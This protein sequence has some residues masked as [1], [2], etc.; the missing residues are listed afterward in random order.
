[1]KFLGV[2]LVMHHKEAEIAGYFS[3]HM[4]LI[5]TGTISEIIL[6]YFIVAILQS[7]YK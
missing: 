3:T 4:M 6:K 7:Y 5:A 2:G 1:M